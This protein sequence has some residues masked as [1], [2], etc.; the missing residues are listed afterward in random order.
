MKEF[1]VWLARH[2]LIVAFAGCLVWHPATAMAQQRSS[3]EGTWKLV[4]TITGLTPVR[5]E[6]PFSKQGRADFKANR[7]RRDDDVRVESPDPAD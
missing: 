1:K 3:L 2:S 5:G 4:S 6:I 7:A